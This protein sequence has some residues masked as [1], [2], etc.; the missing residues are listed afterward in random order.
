MTPVLA[1]D[2]TRNHGPTAPNHVD[3]AVEGQSITG[4]APGTSTPSASSSFSRFRRGTAAICGR[5]RRRSFPT[6]YAC[7]GRPSMPRTIG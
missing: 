7:A 2:D 5:S 3:G 4:A 6:R 1:V